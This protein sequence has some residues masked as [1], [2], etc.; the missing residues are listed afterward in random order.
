MRHLSI[1]SFVLFSVSLTACTAAVDDDAVGAASVA[2]TSVPND[3]ACITLTATGS[4]TVT[5][6]YD[7][8]TG[9]SSVLALNSLPVG[10]V[11]FRGDAYTGACSTVTASSVP[12]FIA[13]PVD[14]VVTTGGVTP[15]TLMMRRNGQSSVS[16]D[17]EDQGATLRTLTVTK[18]AAGAGTVVSMPS[19]I[20]CGADCSEAFA[21]GTTVTL[22]AAP[23]TGSTFLG[24]NGACT[25]T[26]ACAVTM[27]VAKSVTASFGSAGHVLTIAKT[28]NGAGTVTASGAGINCGTDCSEAYAHGTMVGLTAT[29]ATGSLFAGWTGGG[30]TGTGFCTVTMTAATSVT[31]NFTTNVHALTVNTIGSGT[32][33]SQPFGISCG[34]DCT[35]M[36][37]AGTTVQLTATPANFFIGFT[38]WS[39]ACTGTGACIVNMNQAH[40]VTATFSN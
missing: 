12:T 18:A 21:N 1:A 25:G 3:V 31:A 26:G 32:V 7:V 4:R 40:N 14:A 19:G 2:I 13:E 9:Q 6:N 37:P 11:A 8:V 28:G 10:T 33:T 17:W 34:A 35:E 5:R 30:C 23:A 24:W 20:N 15:V 39:G 29:P 22:N 27:D 36:F 16:V 38:G